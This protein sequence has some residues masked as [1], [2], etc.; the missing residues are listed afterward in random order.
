MFLFFLSFYTGFSQNDSVRIELYRYNKVKY[1]D[2]IES[3]TINITSYLK[4]INHSYFVLEFD[5]TEKMKSYLTFTDK[6]RSLLL[7]VQNIKSKFNEKNKFTMIVV[8][9]ES[10]SGEIIE[11]TFISLKSGALQVNNLTKRK[12]IYMLQMK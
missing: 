7:I 6:S 12:Q 10:E 3:S 11:L 1:I 4:T 5:D 2:S 8:T 9:T